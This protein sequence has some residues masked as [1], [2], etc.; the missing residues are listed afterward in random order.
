MTSPVRAEVVRGPQILDR[1]TPGRTGLDR[2][3]TQAPT[4][5]QTPG[6]YRAW[7]MRAARSELA[8]PILLEAGV[9]GGGRVHVALQVHQTTAGPVLRPLSW[10]W[11][12]YHDA[13][14]MTPGGH[15]DAPRV[16]AEAVDHLQ[17]I[18]RARLDLPD[19]LDGG[20]LHRAAVQLGARLRSSSTVVS[21]DLGD[22][23][24]VRSIVTRKETARKARRLA[25]LGQLSLVHLRDPAD[26][27]PRLPTFFAM[28]A[29]Q[30]KDR[31]D[32]VAPFDGGVVDQTF[33]AVAAQPDAGVLL[34]ELQL[35]SSPLAM[36]FGF[37]HRGR[38]WGYRTAYDR[39][40][41]RLS[42]GHQL[43]VQMIID[44]SRSPVHTFD[45]MRGGYAYKLEY[46]SS[47]SANVHAERDLP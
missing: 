36:Y 44:F 12:D 24:H 33:A 25:R 47:V 13:C 30:W 22:A 31:A 39:R 28:H 41:W 45:L 27:A 15:P 40:Y 35:D 23:E 10:P 19:L 3:M 21:I 6:W 20:L 38:Y 18:E 37:L 17:G 42:P 26:L 46:A 9:P 16:L 7:I 11:A 43:V 32:V 29:A 1:L 5:F 34:T 2:A 14:D 4:P 8:T